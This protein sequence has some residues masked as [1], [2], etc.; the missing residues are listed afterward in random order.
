MSISR[1]SQRQILA[2]RPQ[3]SHALFCLMCRRETRWPLSLAS[4]LP[5]FPATVTKSSHSRHEGPSSCPSSEENVS[6]LEDTRQLQ[7]VNFRGRGWYTTGGQTG[8]N[9][10]GWDTRTGAQKPIQMFGPLTRTSGRFHLL[11]WEQSRGKTGR[12][13]DESPETRSV[14]ARGLSV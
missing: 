5:S 13:S 14:G 2:Q 6:A 7:S 3:H 12:N 1:D 9:A 10:G 4:R 8:D 11:T